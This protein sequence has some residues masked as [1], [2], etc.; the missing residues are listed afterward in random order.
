MMMMINLPDHHY[1][2]HYHSRAKTAVAQP[3]QLRTALPRSLA[4]ALIR[5]MRL[6]GALR[7]RVR[8]EAEVRCRRCLRLRLRLRLRCG[9]LGCNSLGSSPPLPGRPG[10]VCA[11]LPTPR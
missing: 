5:C 8:A 7:T 11:P 6:T 9:G 1:Q 2:H 3:C 4:R 10:G